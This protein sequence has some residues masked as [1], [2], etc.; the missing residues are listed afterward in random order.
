MLTEAV[1]ETSTPTSLKINNVAQDELIVLRSVSGLSS[2]KNTLFT[3][4]FGGEGGYYQ[5]RRREG[6]N[7]VFD[8]RLQ[9]NYADNVE[10]SDIREMLY[11]MFLE[12][13]ETSDAVQVRLKDDRKPDRFFRA[14]TETFEADIFAKELRAQVSM[15]TTDN[16]L[17]SVT[18]TSH[19]NNTGGWFNYT[20]DYD[21]S[22]D[23]GFD[24]VIKV[25]A[26]TNRVT[27]LLGGEFV[28]LN[29]TFAIDDI[30]TVNTVE[31]QKS[32]TQNAVEKMSLM[33]ASSKW[34]QLR[35]KKANNIKVF[36]TNEGDGK[37]ALTSMLYR[38][39]WWGI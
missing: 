29:G 28:Q 18:P 17:R 21:G 35:K 7:P 16:F 12:P 2:V 10:A 22:A 20:F 1:I 39:A 11:T 14:Y 25:L 32:V 31:R 13:S 37:A 9:P 23:T 36:G 33:S 26:P 6:L 34:I 24:M 3:G 27:V 19:V 5:G 38:S 4:Q 15:I 30:L 8:F